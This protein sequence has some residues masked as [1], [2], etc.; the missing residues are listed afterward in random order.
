MDGEDVE[1][2]GGIAGLNRV[3]RCARAPLAMST[4]SIVTLMRPRRKIQSAESSG[5]NP[6]GTSPPAQPG[7]VCDFSPSSESSITRSFVPRAAARVSSFESSS[8]QP[9]TSEEIRRGGALPSMG[10]SNRC[11][12]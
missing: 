5:V 10:M 2:A 12:G 11:I 4:R 3:P 9:T 1:D 6:I 8:G 7:T